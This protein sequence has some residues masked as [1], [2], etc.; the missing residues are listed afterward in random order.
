MV[1]VLLVM[2]TQ[3]GADSHSRLDTRHTRDQFYAS[4]MYTFPL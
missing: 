1:T 3:P 4:A 2:K